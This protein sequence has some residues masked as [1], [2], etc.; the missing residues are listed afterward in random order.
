MWEAHILLIH[1]KL[2]P[3]LVR[4]TTAHTDLVLDHKL[5]ILLEV[6]VLHDHQSLAPAQRVHHHHEPI[7]VEHGQEHDV[8]AWAII[9][10]MGY[11]GVPET[12]TMTTIL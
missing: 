9:R 2:E 7:A 5:E 10:I 1:E 11:P 12:S 4:P 6:K 8:G 3:D